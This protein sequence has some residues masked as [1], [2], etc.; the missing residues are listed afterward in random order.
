LFWVQPVDPALWYCI[1]AKEELNRLHRDYVDDC[2]MNA[3]RCVS[4]AVSSRKPA[5]RSKSSSRLSNPLHG[6]VI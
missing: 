1:A 3:I 2:V 6:G 5:F 4:H